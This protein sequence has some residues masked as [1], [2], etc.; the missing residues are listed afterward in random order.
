MGVSIVCDIELVVV[1]R[2]VG[3]ILIGEGVFICGVE[4]GYE[5]KEDFFVIWVVC[6]G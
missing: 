3:V 2:V 6:C 4:V 5:F 1:V